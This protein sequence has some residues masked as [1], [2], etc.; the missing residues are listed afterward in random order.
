MEKLSIEEFYVRA[1]KRLKSPERKGVHVVFSGLNAAAKAYYGPD[2]DVKAATDTLERAGKI[3]GRPVAG[4]GGKGG[5]V[6]YLP[7][8]MPKSPINV[9]AK[10][11]SEE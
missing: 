4:K 3:V 9:L 1:I 2:F 11:L 6:I 10:I 8:D 5:Y 7:E